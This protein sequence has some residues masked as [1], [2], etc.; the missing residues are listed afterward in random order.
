MAI[1]RDAVVSYAK[2]F[3][4]LPCRDGTVWLANEPIVIASEISKRKLSPGEWMGAFLYYPGAKKARGS[5][6]REAWTLEGLYL[7]KS[8][9]AARLRS[10]QMAA[11]YPDAI[12]VASWYDNAADELLT[13]PPRFSGLN[14][15]AHFVTECL[16]AGGETGLRTVSV[17]ALLNSLT[18]HS[19]T[20]T[21]ARTVGKGRAQAIM[22]A[23]LLKRGDV[24][25]F[26]KTAHSHG[27]STIYLGASKMAMHT[28]SNHSESTLWGGDWSN[29]MTEEHNLVT[30]IHWNEGD[31]Y[32]SASDAIPGYWIVS[33]R[34]AT[35]YY[36]FRKGG[37]VVYS[38]TKPA[39]FMAAPS[40]IDGSGYWFESATGIDISWT[41]TGSLEEFI[42]P[43]M[44][45]GVAMGGLWNGSEPIVATKKLGP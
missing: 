18:S 24:L 39:N 34:G 4:Y 32:T 14:D 8:T 38:K 5:A 37:R 36:Y 29:S 27:H 21:L 25:I 16:A 11:S 31:T 42:R 9:S 41:S 2:Q 33:W 23:G 44:F 22:D 28:F 43:T 26:S 13:H 30:L 17:P 35:Y 40:V 10:D 19:D 12:M 15:C 7:V 20:K 3:W 1:S 45:T 6:P